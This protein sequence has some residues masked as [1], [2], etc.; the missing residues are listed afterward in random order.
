MKTCDES[1]A[2]RPGIAQEVPAELVC[3]DCLRPKAID[4]FRRRCQGGTQ[5]I[6]Q[7][8]SCHAYA[9][10]LRRYGKRSAGHS[11]E[12]RKMLTRLRRARS[13]RE[14]EVVC[15]AMVT[16]LGGPQRFLARWTQQAAAELPNGGLAAFRHLDAIL[17]LIRYLDQR[18]ADRAQAKGAWLHSLS[19][20]ELERLFPSQSPPETT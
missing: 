2:G 3:R 8:R 19:D 10:R 17:R 9:E 4:E 20:T 16:A 1:P 18:V 6:R 11:R 12:M 13:Q 5:R 15:A 14:V 7:C